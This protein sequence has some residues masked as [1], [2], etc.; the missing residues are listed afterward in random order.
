VYVPLP[1]R[2][3]RQDI[4]AAAI[5]ARSFGTLISAPGGDIHISHLPFLCEFNDGKLELI[6]HLARQNPQAG[7]LVDGGDAVASF[8]L[9]EAYISP[10]WY[11]LKQE[12]GRVVPTWNYIAIEARGPMEL[13]DDPTDVLAIVD[14]L[15]ARHEAGRP[16]PWSS[17]DAPAEYI[18]TLVKGIVGVRMRPHTLTGAWK[19]DQ[20]KREVDRLGAVAGLRGDDGKLQM[21]NWM[22]NPRWT[23]SGDQ[24]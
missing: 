21:A 3:D 5:G 1:F 12:T 8:L 11:P 18:A 20:H 9:D 4:L 15:T 14:A 24:R 6:A 17:T 19:L 16:Q 23:V 10:R 13:I 22:E 2:E 7:R